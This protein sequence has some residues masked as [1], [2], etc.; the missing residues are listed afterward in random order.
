MALGANNLS[1][2]WHKL[3]Q[4][5]AETAQNERDEFVLQGFINGSMKR[6]PAMAE[7]FLDNA[8]ADPVLGPLF[9]AIQTAVKIQANGAA[10][11]ERSLELGLAPVWIY[12]NLAYGRVA[13]SIPPPLFRRLIAKILALAEGFPCALEILYMRL[14]SLKNDQM[15]IDEDFILSCK[16]VLAQCDF[17]RP[18][19][20]DSESYRLAEIVNIGL[21]GEE[22]HDLTK[23]ICK[24]ISSAAAA[25]RISL[26]EDHKFL[27]NLFKT[28]TA[29]ALDELLGHEAT[30]GFHSYI[31]D[32]DLDRWNPFIPI[33]ED[34][35]LKWAELDPNIR[36]PN[37]ASVV[38]LF[39]KAEDKPSLTWSSIALSILD[40]SP[41]KLRVLDEY[42]KRFWP[43]GWSGSLADIHEKYR[44][45]P[46]A[47]LTYPDPHVVRW[48]QEQDAELVQEIER[49]RIREKQRDE[50]FE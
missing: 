22:A 25:Y 37:L 14:Y 9:P 1:D 31:S 7:Y 38:P 47:L 32:D 24:K 50:R 34:A 27:E 3:T 19:F 35:L 46:Q 30:I 4:A 23:A 36:C 26:S 42:A 28:Q 33:P 21:V 20:N 41:N 2:I 39:N 45:L 15:P 49:E 44:A 5:L 10:R 40:M 11:L 43:C 6:D 16:D 8:V 12:K 18:R 48:A 29:V 13:D 17:D